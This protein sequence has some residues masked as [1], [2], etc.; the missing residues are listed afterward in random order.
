MTR[1]ARMVDSLAKALPNRISRRGFFAGSA[2]VG[3]A[4][5]L[6][7]VT[8]LIKPGS[9]YAAVCNCHGSSCG[10]G[11]ACCDGYT[12]FCCTITGANS[13]PAGTLL[14][15]WWKADGTQFCG[16][17]RYYMDCNSDCGGCGCGGGGVCSG[18]CSGTGCG[19]ANGDC[20]NRA[21]GCNEFRYGQCHQEIPCIGPIVCRVVTCVPPW[22]IDGTC[23]TT[24][25]IDQ[26]TGPHDR[27]CLHSVIGALDAATEVT[28]G[29]RVSG[30]ALDFDTQAS[31]AIHAYVDGKLVNA[32]SASLA[33]PDVAGVYPGYG[34]SHGY[35]FVVPATSGKAHTVC[36][37]GINS[38]YQAGGNPLLGCSTVLPHGP[39]GNIEL[40]DSKPASLR[41]AGWVI[42]PDAASPVTLQVLID[43]VVAGQ[44]VA[45][46][47]RPD[48]A[49][50]YPAAGPAHGFDLTVPMTTGS[51][52]VCVKAVNIGA[53]ADVQ[54]DCRTIEF[55]VPF[56]SIEVIEPGLPGIRVAGWVIDPDTTSPVQLEISVDG[57]APTTITASL[58]RPDVGNAF[59]GSGSA[60]GFD[61]TVAATP[62][63]HQ[64]RVKALNIGTGPDPDLALRSVTV[65]TGNPFGIVDFITAGPDLVEVIGW[66]IDPDT[67]ASVTIRVDVDGVAAGSA[68]ANLGRPDVAA[69]YAGYGAAH[70]FRFTVPAAGGLRNVCVTAV[71][72]LGGSD[73]QLV[74]RNVFVGGAPFGSLDL[75]HP[76]PGGI[77]VAG[78]AIDPDTAS[79]AAL[80]ISVD[81]TVVAT[82]A[83]GIP[84]PDLPAFFPLYG[85]NHGFDLVVPSSGGAHTVCVTAVNTL[86]GTGNVTLGCKSAQV[87][88]GSPFG[89]V[90]VFQ[91][92]AG[93]VHVAGWAIDP[94]TAASIG[95]EV[96][97]DGVVAGTTTASLGRADVGAFY[98]EYGPN[99]GYGITV[100]AASGSRQ[101]CV[102][103]TNVGGGT[104]PVLLR[105]A[106]V[107]VP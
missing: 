43:N 22:A 33:R 32:A 63:V 99:H 105:C 64:V 1:T 45:S 80:S 88:T 38:G 53:G 85:P 19:C 30:W 69:A 55:G 72:L 56:G 34:P 6:D 66:V 51:H 65:P 17:P 46:A 87:P 86:S 37:Y 95:I 24:T 74:C 83:A 2:V 41:V 54:L 20:N 92:A 27:D 52:Q 103:A 101:V 7:P 76:V 59:P 61:T 60:H 49:N 48:V 25:R 47:N 11:A 75:V 18:G 29:I 90:D 8:Y 91:P 97:V 96:R 104:G 40:Y 102:Y 14:A 21:A 68:P 70:G 13:C 4:L 36:V 23:T 94:D 107:A 57:G 12:E 62:G 16:G 84:R 31:V 5:A 26:A 10:C 58:V 42:D 89:V 15:G 82:P 28:G 35:D 98:T 77:R 3:S 9:A 71:N 50:I 67:K 44:T 78:W 93:S 106:T 81:G 39:F 79:P 100:P 73:A